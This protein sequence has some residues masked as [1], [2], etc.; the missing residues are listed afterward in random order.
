MRRTV[1][2]AMGDFGQATLPSSIGV[3]GSGLAS[4]VREA[5]YYYLNDSGSG[6]RG[7]RYPHLHEDA[8]VAEET[9]DVPLE[10]EGPI[11]ASFE[12]EAERQG[13]EAERLLRYA[14]QYYYADLDSGRVTER[15][16]DDLG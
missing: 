4:L 9:I 3:N 1:P 16:V 14:L 6:R 11:W 10:I 12:Q 15:I 13:V 7:W 5:V 2:I 8:T